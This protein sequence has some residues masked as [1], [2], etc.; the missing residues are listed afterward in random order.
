MPS[1]TG[2]VHIKSAY[3]VAETLGRLQQMLHDLK[4]NL[5]TVIDHSGAAE[6]V[7]LT[8]HP[9]ELAIFGNPQGGT[10]AMVAVP[11]L[12]IDLPMKALV[13]EDAEGV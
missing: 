13:W 9:T 8:M 11:S 3:S 12:A 4:I 1:G 7:G 6:S 2:I 10:P 5:F